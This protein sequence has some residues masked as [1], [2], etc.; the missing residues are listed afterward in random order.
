MSLT[1]PAFIDALRG[2]FRRF[3]D[4]SPPHRRLAISDEGVRLISAKSGR[5]LWMFRW[6]NLEEIVSYKVDAITV[7]HLCIGFREAGQTLHVT[8]EDTPG[9]EPLCV[10]LEHR[11]GIAREVLVSAFPPFAETFKILWRAG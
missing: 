7:D 2:A 8:D 6:S 1:Y 9:W 4:A 10:E 11:F 3:G 5:E